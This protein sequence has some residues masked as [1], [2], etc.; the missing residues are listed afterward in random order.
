[1]ITIFII[2]GSF[3]AILCGVILFFYYAYLG[4][5]DVT[6][7]ALDGFGF[8]MGIVLVIIGVIDR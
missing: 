4:Q 8:G 5:I 2:L 1:M 7:G 3:L 6:T